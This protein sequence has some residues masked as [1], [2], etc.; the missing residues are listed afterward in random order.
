MISEIYPSHDINE[1]LYK[2]GPISPGNYDSLMFLDLIIHHYFKSGDINCY[3]KYYLRY[4]MNVP[5]ESIN[6]RVYR[7][8]VHLCENLYLEYDQKI[9]PYGDSSNRYIIQAHINIKIHIQGVYIQAIA[10]LNINDSD[11]T[12]KKF[13]ELFKVLDSWVYVENPAMEANF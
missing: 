13:K 12:R 8:S 3:R 4:L 10:N 2:A 6:N 11:E 7:D 5:N 1:I 9:R